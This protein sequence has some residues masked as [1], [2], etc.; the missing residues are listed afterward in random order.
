MAAAFNSPSLQGL[1]GDASPCV[2]NPSG[3]FWLAVMKSKAVS[4]Q[5]KE[6]FLTCL[7]FSIF[8]FS[9]SISSVI[10][11]IKAYVKS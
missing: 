7:V 10:F 1:A 2:Q 9:V 8:L 11:H 6:I 3:V 4:E 5:H